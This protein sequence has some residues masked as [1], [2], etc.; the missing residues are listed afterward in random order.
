M[1]TKF[2]ALG[3]LVLMATAVFATIAIKR[4]KPAKITESPVLQQRQFE[5]GPVQMIRFVL[6]EDGIYPGMAKVKQGLINLA[7]ED[8]SHGSSGLVIER[9]TSDA[10]DTART[11]VGEVRR[12]E[13]ELRGR[14]VL[15]LTPGSYYVFDSSRP[16]NKAVLLVQP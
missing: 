1:R 15:K 12:T 4:R 13:K 11:R 9:A 3:L 2:I 7:I 16:K 14:E 5:R 8:R 6:F 10:R